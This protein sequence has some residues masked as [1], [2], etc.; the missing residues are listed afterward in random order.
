M[1]NDNQVTSPSEDVVVIDQFDAEG[2]KKNLET[3][4]AQK[5]HWRE[6]AEKEASEKS[7]LQKKLAELE[8]ASSKP[9]Q[10][11]K[12]PEAPKPDFDSIWDNIEAIQGLSTD[13]VVELRSEAKALGVSPVNYIKSKA[14]QAHLKEFR[15]T[16]KSQEATPTPSKRIPVFNGK[17][18]DS[19]LSD[20]N[21]SAGDK[22]KAFEARMNSRKGLNQ[23]V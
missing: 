2:L 7:E 3:T 15:S 9:L 16:K 5:K 20:P 4:L 11:E 13:E 19:I 12:A 8:K 18:I 21:A 6:K 10:E 14:G 23:T 1:Q 22:Q 17:P